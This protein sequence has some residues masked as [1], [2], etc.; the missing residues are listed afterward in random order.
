MLLLPPVGDRAGGHMRRGMFAHHSRAVAEFSGPPMTVLSK[1]ARFPKS[2]LKK[3]TPSG[4]ICNRGSRFAF[5]SAPASS[6]SARQCACDYHEDAT[7]KAYAIGGR[8][9]RN[10]EPPIGGQARG[11]RKPY[12]NSLLHDTDSI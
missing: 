9:I 8:R 4:P 10:F 1:N 6:R 12:T 7:A 2:R 5:G 11:R 3:G